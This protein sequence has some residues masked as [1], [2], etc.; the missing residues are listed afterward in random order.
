MA[1]NNLPISISLGN[2]KMGAVP[3]WS[4]TPGVTCSPEA[5]KTCF[6][7]GCYAKK[8]YKLRPTVRNAYDR[9]TKF[10]ME[11][12]PEF[13]RIMDLWLQLNEPRRF[14]VHVSGD[15]FSREYAEAWIEIANRNPGT[16]FL[17]FTKQFAIVDGLKFPENFKLYLSGW[18]GMEIPEHLRKQYHTAW[19]QDGTETRIP[20]GCHECPGNCNTCKK[21]CWDGDGDTYFHKH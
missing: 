16:V 20:E 3:S 2:S 11:N 9:N 10:V 12:L 21:F 5:C 1:K 13:I 19:M 17:A 4:L 8:L 7:G 18:P 14:R 6:V 15:F